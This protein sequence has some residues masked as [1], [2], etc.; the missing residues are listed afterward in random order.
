[1]DKTKS[2]TISMAMV[3]IIFFT[4]VIASA[5]TTYTTKDGYVVATTKENLEKVIRYLV[6]KDDAAVQSLVDSGQAM[7]LKPGVKVYI[8]SHSWGKI[9][10]RPVGIDG[11]LWTVMEAVE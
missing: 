7:P 6:A 8:E 4:A 5:Q 11:T 9:E 3:A 2:I 10:I 1:M